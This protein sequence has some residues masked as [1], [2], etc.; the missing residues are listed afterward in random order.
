M[1]SP[2]TPSD[3]AVRLSL[4]A[5]H[6]RFHNASLVLR[7]RLFDLQLCEHLFDDRANL[8]FIHQLG[9]KFAVDLHAQ[10][11]FLDGLHAIRRRSVDR[12]LRLLDF[13][14]DD[15]VLLFLRQIRALIDLLALER[16][17]QQTQCISSRSSSSWAALPPPWRRQRK[18][19]IMSVLLPGT[20]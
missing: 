15:G 20:T 14:E 7:R 12:L 4:D 18:S 16:G 8:V 13:A 6:Q 9:H 1:A 19:E 17:E 3:S 2:S 10:L 11:G 5:R